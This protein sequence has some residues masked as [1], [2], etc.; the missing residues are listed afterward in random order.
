MPSNYDKLADNHLTTEKI[1]GNQNW[2][3]QLDTLPGDLVDAIVTN[4]IENQWEWLKRNGLV[5]DAMDR[6]EW[7]Q[8]VNNLD[9]EIVRE[10]ILAARTTRGEGGQDF[11]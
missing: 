8:A 6:D 4:L 3:N 2:Q 1:D 7:R 11:S 10:I 9:W 5:T